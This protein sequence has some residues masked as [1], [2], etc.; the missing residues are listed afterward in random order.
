MIHYLLALS[1]HRVGQ[2]YD[3]RRWF[4][5]AEA[6]LDSADKLAAEQP[7]PPPD[8]FLVNDLNARALQRQARAVFA[9][10][11]NGAKTQAALK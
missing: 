4:Q 9:G 5:I 3:A 8:Y 1:H 7:I 6:S 11:K 2:E 10:E